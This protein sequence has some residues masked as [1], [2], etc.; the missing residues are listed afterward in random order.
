MKEFEFYDEDTD[1]LYRDI[2]VLLKSDMI[3][4][5]STVTKRTGDKRY[6]L[7]KKIKVF[8]GA[9]KMDKPVELDVEGTFLVDS[10][11]NINQIDSSAILGWITNLDD[12][13]WYADRLEQGTPQ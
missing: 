2:S 10:N 12:L 5:G 8:T 4:D 9:V 7:K 13:R 1:F 3:P 11:G 6:T